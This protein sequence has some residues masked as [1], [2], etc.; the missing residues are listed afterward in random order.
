M[1]FKSRLPG[2]SS[3]LTRGSRLLTRKLAGVAGYGEAAFECILHAAMAWTMTQALA[4]CAEYRE[5]ISPRV[6]EPDDAVERRDAAAL[7]RFGQASAAAGEI[8]TGTSV[9]RRIA[10]RSIVE[11]WTLDDRTQDDGASHRGIESVAR[12]GDRCS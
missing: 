3:R 2:P 11:P 12:S 10:A 8:R 1:Q 5:A 4:G 7:R 9:L 6:A